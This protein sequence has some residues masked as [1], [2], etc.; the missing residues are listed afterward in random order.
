MQL[1][2]QQQ[3]FRTARGTTDGICV[4]KVVH[5]IT[6][7]KK[8]HMRYFF[9]LSAAFDHVERRWLFQTI[10]NM[11]PERFNS[12]MLQLLESLNSSTALAESPDNKFRLTVG[13][14]QGGPESPML[15]NLFMDFLM[16]IYLDTCKNE[17][18]KF[19]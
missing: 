17:N 19:L 6:N 5:Q 13:V 3:V 8:R 14:R 15:Y 4:A 1:L 11:F 12:E 10:R 18:I 16:R 9:D 2:N 7:I